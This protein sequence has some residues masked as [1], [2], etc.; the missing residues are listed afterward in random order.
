MSQCSYGITKYF[1]HLKLDASQHILALS[2][3]ETN[4]PKQLR[5]LAVSHFLEGKNRTEIARNLKVSRTSVNKWVADYLLDD[6]PA[7]DT[8]KDKG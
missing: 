3:A 2:R 8:K 6:V 7:L 5:L 4:A 1:T